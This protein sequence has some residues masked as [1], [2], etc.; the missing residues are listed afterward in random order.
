MNP[1]LG[2]G[3]LRPLR[4]DR[5]ADFVADGGD[6]LVRSAVGQILGTRASSESS[7]G[8]LAWRPEFGSLLF[9]LRHR[10]N[11]AVLQELARVYVVD[12]LT[13][14]EPRVIVQT[15]RVST[16]EQEGADVLAVRVGYS[17][18]RRNVSG[19]RVVVPSIQQTVLVR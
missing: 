14:W 19:N 9:L 12:A 6:A 11:D 16:E 15:V 13:R 5:K 1:V 18:I 7:Q 10:K 17:L 4:R 3:L 8:E 2:F